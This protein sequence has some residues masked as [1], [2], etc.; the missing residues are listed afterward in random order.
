M[1][2]NIQSFFRHKDK[3]LRDNR[4]IFT[5]MLVGAILSL[6]AAFVLSVES[7]QLAKNPNTLLSCSI[8]IIVNCATVAK[9]PSA[10]LL[11]FPNSFLGMV[12]EPI[13]ITVA[14]AGLAGVKFPRAFM[15]AAQIGY[16]LGLIFAYYL[17]YVSFV[18]I[19]A[20]CPW[21]LLV[22]LTT[23]LVFF[24]ITRYNIREDN[25]Y[26]PKNISESL[27]R[28]VKKDY[29]KLLLASLIVLVIAAILIKYGDGLFA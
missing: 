7:F 4:W 3:N 28:W 1:F 27:Q 20:L 17:F 8:N 23:T 18:I 26:L 24:A 15:F 14:I 29:D 9:H 22:T 6:I 19:Q 25:L 13:V 12:A 5:S 16:S 2:K 11:G 21:C 10:Q